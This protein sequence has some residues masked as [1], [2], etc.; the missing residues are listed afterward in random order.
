M[1]YF[2]LILL[3][4]SEVSLAS[5]TRTLPGDAIKTSG[6][7]TAS[8]PAVTG[9][10]MNSAAIIQEVPSGTVNGSTTAFTLANTPAQ[11]STVIVYLD[12]LR[13]KPTTDYS[14]STNTITF[15]TAPASGQTVTVDYSKY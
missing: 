11:A 10:V 6:G 7:F 1:K 2:W 13:Q 9:N 14:I 3:V 5:S 15:V 4:V 12:G 8:I